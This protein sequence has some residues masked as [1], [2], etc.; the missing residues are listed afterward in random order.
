ML[1]QRIAS[2]VG[3][4]CLTAGI[5]AA[6]QP[7]AVLPQGVKAVWDL[8][9]AQREATP[10][11]ERVCINGLWRWQPAETDAAAVPDGAWGYFKV[12]GSWPGIT[13]YMQ[14]DTQTVYANPA[15]ADV[16]LRGVSAA[17]YQREVTVPADWAGRRIAVTIDCLNSYAKAY[18]DG[19]EAGSVYY[20]SGELDVTSLCR[21]GQTQMLTL[22]VVA[23][24]LRA[25]MMAFN[26]T[27]APQQVRGNVARRGL[28]GDVY[29]VST[30][31]GPRLGDVRVETSVRNWR[32]SF[33]AA[34]EDLAPDGRYVLR[35]QVTDQG[36]PVAQFA[37]EPF[38]GSD[39]ANGRITLTGDWHADKLWDTNTP[40]NQYEF[41]V[42]LADAAGQALDVSIPQRFGFREFWIDGRDFYLNGTRIFLSAIP[43]DN[44]LVSAAS[45]SYDGVKETLKRFHDIG[46]NL[47]YT[48]NYGC[49]PGSHL[50][51]EEAL[52][53]ADD[54]GMLVAF[55]QPH[56]GNYDWNASDANQTNGYARHARSYVRYAQN[57]PSV[58]A[59]S[60]SH[61]GTG[62]TG[63][64]DPDRIDGIYQ[65]TESWSLNTM[66]RALRAEAIVHAMDPS[67]VIYHH[68]SGNLGQ[69]YT[70][71]FYTNF[72]P[73]QEL[74]DWFE[75]WATVGVVP[76]F[77]VEF[78]VPCTWDWSMY[79]GWYDGQRA[80]GSGAVPWELCIAEWNAQFH[81]DRAFQISDLEKRDLRWEAGQFE[82]G[83]VWHRWDYPI[84]LGD[85]RFVE[86]A[87]VLGAYVRDNWR[88]LRTWGLS[89][90]GPWQY[91]DFW[92]PRDGVDRS[93]EDLPV[94][95]ANLQRPG[96]SADY[97]DQR[98]EQVAMAFKASDWV[99]TAAAEALLRNGRPLLAY[100]GGK[101]GEFTEKGHNFLPGET[102]E[103]Q[104]I[105]INNSR[106]SVDCAC[107][108]TLGLPQALQGSAKVTVP[109]GQIER[110]PLNLALPNNLPPG[111][112]ALKA[113]VAFSTGETQ[114]DVFD[115][116]VLAPPHLERPAARI[117][118]FDPQGATAALLTGLGVA[119][120]PVDANGDL[121]GLDVLLVGQHA[122][123]LDGPA[124][125]IGR[126]R[127]GL[128]V[129]VFEQTGDVLEKRFGFR[130][131]EYGLRQVFRRIPDHPLLAGLTEENLRDW[132]GSAT[133]LPPRMAV[134]E[135]PRRGPCIRWCGILLP[136]VWRCGNRGNVASA[137]IEKPARG[138]FLP[139]VDGGYSLQYSPLMEYRE[140]NGMVLFC[141]MDVSGRTEEDPAGD[142]LAANI[143]RYVSAWQPAPRR[144]VVYAGEAEGRAHLERDGFAVQ[145]Y[146]EA[147]LTADKVLVLARGCREQLAQNVAAVA[148][149]LRD[150]GRV[151]ALGLD[152]E[153]ADVCL[154]VKVG[155]NDAEHIAT[156]FDRFGTG[157]PFAGVGPADV[158]NR[159]PR[160]FPLVASGAEPVGDGILAKAG[161]AD[162]VYCQITPYDISNA[163][164]AVASFQ[165]DAGDAADGKQSALIA[166][167]TAPRAELAQKI[168]AGDV[169]KTYTFAASFKSV[170]G[171][172]L[173]RLE[174][175]RAGSPYDRAARGEDVPV[176][177][178]GWTELH[179]TF[180]VKNAFPEGWQPHIYVSGEGA[181]VRAD[182]F[183][184]YEGDYVP[185]GTPGR[186]DPENRIANA[187]FEDG[188][189]TWWFSA[190]EQYNLRRTY[191]RTSF[192]LA[193]LL[194]NMGA[195]GQTPLLARF[196]SPVQAGEERCLDGLYLDT[197]EEWDYPYRFFRW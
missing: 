55:S 77:L 178:D 39:A 148:A 58:V 151:L 173:V 46:V 112:Y 108:W 126:V 62:Y 81:G 59:Y 153:E 176:G 193:R 6:A 14:K 100:V 161:G 165:A 186:Q 109:T 65:P 136:Q 160:D 124:P 129:V 48:H 98:Y 93:R 187:S 184:F 125:D 117:G 91:S 36:P 121:S 116:D 63:D 152:Q 25:T 123:T 111:Q 72:S 42:T 192:L 180:Q 150:G 167:G 87:P 97:I 133:V 110:I 74:S 28:C 52:R 29:L 10:T 90:F 157:S 23:A 92:L 162:L 5:A 147:P 114:D 131:A 104:L 191:R 107:T 132:R 105:V 51:W 26:D 16:S 88:S 174:V 31:R 113:T 143:V 57:H 19:R 168:A 13:D 67:R 53:A 15:W 8:G 32:I 85:R 64:M 78:G 195:A 70:S 177:P 82:A 61:N 27:A 142:A 115:V 120:R 154:P 73:M 134:E 37:G 40:Q 49:A 34:V 156:Y 2:I 155:M 141:Q 190:H 118:L 181:R 159:S 171:P 144:T 99:P 69:M 22:L 75:H 60:M 182:A 94:D 71:N 9:T 197:P 194:A 95:W 139:I 3:F 185:A 43:V 68:S 164:G 18:V 102:V 96:F 76:A 4:L 122:L 140:G 83:N 188:T 196:S 35:A 135:A 158:H 50:S 24:P 183:R 137:L 21:P 163:Q 149:F 89:A 84:A 38:S 145:A 170:G 66:R 103:K 179:V 12:P 128:K 175:E 138:D 106:Q 130:V 41:S 33:D 146:G 172:A 11:R 169:G 189:G 30:P 44:A 119:Y 56:F 20:P 7:A 80:F 127:D 79:R 166:V 47:V 54:V 86:R 1:A 45:A 101:A 17:W